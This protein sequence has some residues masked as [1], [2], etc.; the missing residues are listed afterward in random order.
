MN[1]HDTRPCNLPGLEGAVL[2]LLIG[3]A[4]L[5]P[6]LP[7]LGAEGPNLILNPSDL[8]VR[9]L[10]SGGRAA[11]L[12]VLRWPL[13]YSYRIEV[14]DRWVEDLDSDGVVRVELAEGLPER[15]AWVVVDLSN[16]EVVTL[17][18]GVDAPPE[19]GPSTAAFD[20]STG[21]VTDVRRMLAVLF[22]RPGSGSAPEGAWFGFATDGDGMDA[23]GLGDGSITMTSERMIPLTGGDATAAATGFSGGDV[24]AGI[25]ARTLAVWV[26]RPGGPVAVEGGAR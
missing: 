17:A 21:S 3:A 19:A 11:V 25:D 16:G 20:A 9:S 7:A 2:S 1:T 6:T 22:A 5:A 12:G 8:E 10:T 23:D 24:V 18:T 14:I 26:E 15:T 4:I 13:D